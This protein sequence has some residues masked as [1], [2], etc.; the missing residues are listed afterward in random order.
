MS[1]CRAGAA[2]ARRRYDELMRQGFSVELARLHEELA[3]RDFSDQNRKASPLRPAEDAVTLDTSLLSV[4]EATAMVV[5][6]CEVRRKN[7]EV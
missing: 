7:K 3:A 6:L 4:E 5:A 2:R 1:A